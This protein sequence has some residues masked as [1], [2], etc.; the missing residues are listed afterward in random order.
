MSSL[1]DYKNNDKQCEEGEDSILQK[2]F[3]LIDKKCNYCVEFGAGDGIK[4]SITYSFRQK[5]SNSLLMDGCVIMDEYKDGRK[6]DRR[7]A[8]SA[9][10]NMEEIK[11]SKADVKIEFITKE[12]INELFEKYNVP[13]DFNL[14]VIDID[15]NDYW[16]WK[17]LNY[18]P[19]IVM[20]EF[21]QWIE[22]DLNIVIKYNKDFKTKIK[23]RYTSASCKAM[24][25]LGR[26]KGYTLVSICADNMI[27]VKNNLADLVTIDKESQNNWKI[28]YQKAKLKSKYKYNNYGQWI[29]LDE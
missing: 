1:L 5:G 15:G 3:D 23:D 18:Y 28:L 12:N 14:L 11:K 16:I 6:F 29:D 25:N 17:A 26:E 21:N 27:F 20:I 9:D 22:P 7:L 4:H 24:F 2:I 13:K 10:V 19:D 8:T